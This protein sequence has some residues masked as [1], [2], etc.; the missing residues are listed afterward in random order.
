MNFDYSFLY[1]LIQDN[2]GVFTLCTP[3]SIVNFQ[4]ALI[5]LANSQLD[6]CQQQV[7]VI[8]LITKEIHHKSFR[9]RP[10]K[11]IVKS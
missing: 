11:R 4:D 9:K 3:C 2:K 5:F 10:L 8:V 1:T 7:T 6:Q